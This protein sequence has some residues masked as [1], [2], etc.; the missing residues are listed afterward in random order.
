MSKGLGKRYIEDKRNHK[1][2]TA[3]LENRMFLTMKG[4]RKIAMPRYYKDKIYEEDIRQLVAA[5]QMEKVREHNKQQ[6]I[7]PDYWDNM[8]RRSRSIHEAFETMYYEALKGRN[9]I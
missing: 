4:G 9:K 1:W 2:H 8:E 5:L 3:D 6:S 7:K